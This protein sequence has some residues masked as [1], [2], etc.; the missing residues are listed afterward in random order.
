MLK[1]GLYPSIPLQKALQV[2]RQK[3]EADDTLSSR[4]D[5][6]VDDIMK[7]FKISM[8]TY[9]KTL[10]GKI[11]VQVDGCPIGKSISGE[12]A[13]IYMNWFEETYVFNETN[14]FKPIFWKRMRDDI[15][16]IWKKGDLEENQKLGSDDLDRFLWKLNCFEKRIEFTLEREKDGV[17]PF[18]DLL[19]R[20]EKDSFITNKGLQ[21]RDAH[22]KVHSLEVKPF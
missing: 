14:D 16:L 10:D 3:L 9:F 11:W 8:E 7:L 12:I 17:L 18:L 13:E 6:N 1:N 19:I 20:R 15:L 4:T 22:P 2:I 21:E 5:W